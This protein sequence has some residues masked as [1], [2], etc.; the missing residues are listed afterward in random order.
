[1]TQRGQSA[2][3]TEQQ[4]GATGRQTT[5]VVASGGTI[6]VEKG[7]KLDLS[8]S[9]GSI[10]LA[11]GEIKAS[12]LAGNLASGTVPL[13]AHLLAGLKLA[14]AE[15]LATGIGV[16]LLT[17]SGDPSLELTSS[18]DQSL[19]VNYTSAI[20]TLRWGWPPPL[21]CHMTTGACSGL[22]RRRGRSS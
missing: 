9:T 19:Y 17:T 12:H 10:L 15:T 6:R 11:T 13:G 20:V 1:M 2:I 22:P 16:Q 4:R 18:G 14:S 5:M 21:S 8:S 7:G 3:Y